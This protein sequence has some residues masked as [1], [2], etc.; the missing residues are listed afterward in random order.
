M[1]LYFQTNQYVWS[2]K[3]LVARTCNGFLRS[4]L[5]VQIVNMVDMVEILLMAARST[6]RAIHINFFALYTG[7]RVGLKNMRAPS[8]KQERRWRSVY[9]LMIKFNCETSALWKRGRQFSP[10]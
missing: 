8:C 7:L 3:Y 2:F 5:T 1:C 10:Y 4:P 6:Q 9:C